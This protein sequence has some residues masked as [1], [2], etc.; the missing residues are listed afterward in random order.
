MDTAGSDDRGGQPHD[1]L[2]REVFGDPRNAGSEL[3]SLL[4]STV[5]ER[6]DLDSLALLSGSFVDS[7]LTQVHSDLLFRTTFDG[8]D[9]Y[10]Y[11]LIEHQSSPD[12]L[13]AF[14]MLRYQVRIWCR[15]LTDTGRAGE[16]TPRRLPMIVPVVIYQGR[17]RWTAPTDIA[18]LLDIDPDTASTLGD[19]VPHVRFLLDDLTS[20]DDSALR[21]RPL[22]PQARTALVLL[23]K[24]P[25]T[26]DATIWLTNWLSDWQELG[27]ESDQ[28]VM[29]LFVTYLLRV[30]NTPRE[31]IEEFAALLGPDAEETIVSTAQKLHDEGRKQG[32]DEGRKEG[33]QQGR[34]EGRKEGRQQGRAEGQAQLLVDMLTARFGQVDAATREIV[35]HATTDQ[36]TTW[37]IRLAQGAPTI[38]EILA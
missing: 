15:Y 27:R 33:R 25:G 34:A 31:S 30:S 8:R 28:R 14:R 3:Q 10:L 6:L 18:E 21:S 13:M 36:L 29:R 16:P 12:G 23:G 24:A 5:A 19:L 37:S 22:T 38:D 2:F 1:A 35:E 32:R 7:D 11:V 26:Q 20:I 17:R 4:P 9:A